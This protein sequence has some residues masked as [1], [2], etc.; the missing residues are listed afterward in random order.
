MGRRRAARK[1]QPSHLVTGLVLGLILGAGLAVGVLM[2]QLWSGERA[3]W[4]PAAPRHPAPP[5]PRAVAPAAPPPA[6]LP[7]LPAQN[8]EESQAPAVVPIPESR[9]VPA[10]P[11]R[12]RVAI[13]FDDAGYGIRAA[14]EI[15]AIGRPVTISVLPHLP[16]SAQIAEDAPAHHVEVILH[17]PVEPDNP[18]IRLGEGGITVAMS[19]TIPAVARAAARVRMGR[20]R[21]VGASQSGRACYA[22]AGAL[23]ARP[24]L[25][26][27]P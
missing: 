16:Y 5:A 17:L 1:Q 2:A 20:A 19:D 24:L 8:P 23:T 13:I 4:G 6:H 11:G 9:P 22:E 15:M 14:Q 7:A 3:S 12:T 26:S 10:Q 25:W 21:T 18:S 27:R